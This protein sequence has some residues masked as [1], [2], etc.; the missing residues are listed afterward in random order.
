VSTFVFWWVGFF[1]TITHADLWN[2]VND[3]S[4]LDIQNQYEYRISALPHQGTI[5]TPPW[6]ETYWATY[7]GSINYRWN[8]STPT[9]YGYRP[10]S[11]EEALM[12]NDSELRQL[13]PSEKFDLFLGRYDYPLVQEA[14]LYSNPRA[15]VW[16]GICDGWSIAAIQFSEPNAVT[17]LNPDGIAVPFGSSDIKGLLSYIAAIHFNAGSRQVGR[18]CGI[19][20]FSSGCSDIN[21]GSLHV[22]FTNLIGLQKKPFVIEIDSG[23][24]IWN[25]PAYSYQYEMIGSALSPLTGRGVQ[26][27]AFLRYTDELEQS[28]WEPV[29]GTDAFASDVLELNYILD[30]NEN[31]EIIGGNW[32]SPS[33]R[34]D[35][36][37]LP[38]NALIFE[39]EFEGMNQILEASGSVSR[40]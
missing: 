6:S 13:A 1:S 16:S 34:P 40:Q 2:P 4:I 20:P 22:I 9:G 24:P 39:D 10:P 23:R 33:D 12:M 26:I 3:P 38:T 5:Q 37:W 15:K 11:R 32:M 31:D 7:L 17:L 30:L 36:A 28:H 14:R 29:V 18:K 27:R 21:A 19:W 35:F 8:A 25:Q